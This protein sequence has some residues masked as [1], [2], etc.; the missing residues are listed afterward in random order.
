M[1]IELV[2]LLQEDVSEDDIDVYIV[3]FLVNDREMFEMVVEI[4]F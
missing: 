2:F 3:V 1:I 4:L